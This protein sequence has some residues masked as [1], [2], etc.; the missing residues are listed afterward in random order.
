MSD[1]QTV[2]GENQYISCLLTKCFPPTVPELSSLKKQKRS[3]KRHGPLP[4]SFRDS[5]L[6]FRFPPRLRRTDWCSFYSRLLLFM[7]I[8]RRGSEEQ[9]QHQGHF[10]KRGFEYMKSD[11]E[12]WKEQQFW[13]CRGHV[14]RV[15]CNRDSSQQIRK[16]LKISAIPLQIG[17]LKFHEVTFIVTK[18]YDSM[19]ARIHLTIKRLFVSL[20]YVAFISAAFLFLYVCLLAST[21][22]EKFIDGT[23]RF[24]FI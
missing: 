11:I 14:T 22:R 19:G 18:R 1:G 21:S 12:V 7:Q 8:R 16:C 20:V 2:V 23:S 17:E 13:N 10:V 24:L 5:N 9:V 6:C 4:S 3:Q 15:C